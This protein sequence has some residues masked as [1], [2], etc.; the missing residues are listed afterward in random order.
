MAEADNDNNLIIL[1]TSPKGKANLKAHQH[2][3]QRYRK[4]WED[5]PAFKPWLQGVFNPFKAKC[6]VCNA[7]MVAELTVIKN[8]ARGKKHTSC[9]KTAHAAQGQLP[10]SLKNVIYNEHFSTKKTAFMAPSKWGPHQKQHYREEWEDDPAF[11]PWLEG[12]SDPF[13]A[14]CRVC[15][16]VM[17]A[18]L[19]VIKNHARG[20]KHGSY[21]TNAPAD[22]VSV[23]KF[24]SKTSNI[25]K[26]FQP[27]IQEVSNLRRVRLIT[28][29]TYDGYLDQIFH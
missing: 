5:D 7:V 26:T 27:K 19:T 9:W 16:V 25:E 22:Q 21:I 2:R 12:V 18:E 15:N 3:S 24:F 4:E 1:K 17:V 10:N 6:R 28:T 11:K 23:A 8:H 14:K 20:K 13:R 29:C